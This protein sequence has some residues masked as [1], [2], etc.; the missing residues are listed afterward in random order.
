MHAA[1][2]ERSPLIEDCMLPAVSRMVEILDSTENPYKHVLRALLSLLQYQQ[3]A[4]SAQAEAMEA[5]G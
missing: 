3:E 4:S 2:Q 1:E 5:C